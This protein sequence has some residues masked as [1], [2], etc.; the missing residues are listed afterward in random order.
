MLWLQH[1]GFQRRTRPDDHSPAEPPRGVLV[2]EAVK[3][4]EEDQ[5]QDFQEG[6][7]RHACLW[8][9][10]IGGAFLA[11]VWLGGLEVCNGRFDT[12]I[13]PRYYYYYYYY[14][15]IQFLIINREKNRDSADPS[16]LCSWSRDIM[17]IVRFFCQLCGGEKKRYYLLSIVLVETRVR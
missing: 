2:R 14:F 9:Y 8:W 3:Q 10:S 13:Y 16:M 15:I 11:V 7:D 1:A 12:G 17:P 5:D 6:E 4:Q